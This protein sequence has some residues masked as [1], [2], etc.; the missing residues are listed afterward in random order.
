MLM[1]LS[2]DMLAP[3]KLK[4]TTPLV[5][6][7]LLRTRFWP[8]TESVPVAVVSKAVEMPLRDDARLVQFQFGLLAGSKGLS[9]VFELKWRVPCPDFVRLS[10]GEPDHAHPAAFCSDPYP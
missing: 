4:T 7:L 3:L 2:P 5:A 6:P 1:L 10:F 8:T 9:V